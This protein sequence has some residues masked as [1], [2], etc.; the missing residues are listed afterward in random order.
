MHHEYPFSTPLPTSKRVSEGRSCAGQI[1]LD[2]G[3]EG[4][5]VAQNGSEFVS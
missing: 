4:P 2:D 3:S 1:R 5:T